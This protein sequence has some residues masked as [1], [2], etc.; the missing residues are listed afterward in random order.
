MR[1]RL[2]NSINWAKVYQHPK[3][4]KNLNDYFRNNHLGKKYFEDILKQS[5]QR[6]NLEQW[7]FA[8]LEVINGASLNLELDFIKGLRK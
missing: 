1:Y 2:F 4:E 7:P 8:N 6:K 3:M 5:L